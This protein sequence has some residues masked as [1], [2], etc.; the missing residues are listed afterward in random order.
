MTM[1]SIQSLNDQAAASL[2]GGTNGCKPAPSPCMPKF[3]SFPCLG[4]IAL[5]VIK[6]PEICISNISI[7]WGKCKPTTPAC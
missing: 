3:P 1:H 6:L 2:T 5:P 4:E 7:D